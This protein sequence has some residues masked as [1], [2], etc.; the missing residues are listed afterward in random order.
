LVT[1]VDAYRL[2]EQQGLV[3]RVHGKGTFVRSTETPVQRRFASQGGQITAFD[4]QLAVADYLP[5]AAVFGIHTR[6]STT[7]VPY[8]MSTA[9]LNPSLSEMAIPQNFSRVLNETSKALYEYGP[10]EG[11]ESLRREVAKYLG[12]FGLTA[13]FEDILITNGVQQAIDIVAR[14]F[15]GPGDVV[16]VE[17]PTYSGAIDVFRSRGANI[18]SIPMDE[19][20]LRLDL[21]LKQCD[22]EPPKLI[23]TMPTFQNPTGIVMSAKRR[24]QLVEL[25]ES[26]QS[27]IL[28]DDSFSDC[29]FQGTPPP[30]IRS[31]DAHGHVIYVKGFSKVFCPGC[32]IAAVVSSGSI[33]NRL[34]AAKSV[35]D[36]GSPTLTQALIQMCLAQPN[37]HQRIERITMALKK[38][39]DIVLEVLAKHAPTGVY[40]TTP[41]GGYNIWIT[42]PPHVNTD[43]LLIQALQSGVSF[44]PSSACYANE[45]V[46]HQLRVSFAFLDDD[47]LREG[48]LRLCE[49]MSDV[50]SGK[51]GC[52]FPV[53]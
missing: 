28:E 23:Y 33:R 17:A 12:E 11:L 51:V 36:L 46:H 45:V 1:V 6:S 42:L 14:T 44:L 53:V 3:D 20:G 8:K 49:W 7:E 50:L 34:V 30:A 10:V 29:S 38:K 22:V 25:A 40:W 2:L 5:R 35:T 9:A 37:R 26:Y 18:M 16:V 21:M 43:A 13:D 41:T 39:R 19:E 32:R 48:V 24:A 4:W 31:F 47:T 52:Q 27:I 15:I